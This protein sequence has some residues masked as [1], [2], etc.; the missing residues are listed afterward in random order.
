M[1]NYR[2]ID[3]EEQHPSMPGEMEMLKRE[4]VATDCQIDEW[5]YE[6]IFEERKES[7]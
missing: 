4:V 6:L 1:A 5:V 7:L 3:F 2:E